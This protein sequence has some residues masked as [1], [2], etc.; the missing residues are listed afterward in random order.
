MRA[1]NSDMQSQVS[2]RS[3]A[4]D[5]SFTEVAFRLP[6][7]ETGDVGGLTEEEEV[8]LKLYSQERKLLKEIKNEKTLLSC[9][10]KFPERSPVK[11]HNKKASSTLQS[12]Q[13]TLESKKE[14]AVLEHIIKR[15]PG[16]PKEQLNNLTIAGLVEDDFSANSSSSCPQI[17][18]I[19]EKKEG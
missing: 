3:K 5:G 19:H 2:L 16:E 4:S 11:M 6:E 13:V 15:K 14:L 7:L 10:D 17:G 8:Q 12:K 1:M 9:L 18:S